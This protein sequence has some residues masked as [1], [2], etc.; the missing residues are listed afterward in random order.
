[1]TQ[2]SPFAAAPPNPYG[3]DFWIGFVPVNLRSNAGNMQLD[4]DPSMRTTTGRALLIQSLLC[5]QTTARGSVIDCP[6]DC[7][8][9]RNY[10][11]DGMTTAQILQLAGTIQSELLKDQRVTSALV[12]GTYSFQTATLS[13]SEAIQSGYGPFTMVLGVSAVTVQLLN[14]NLL[15]GT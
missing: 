8:D 2:P 10:V 6:N 14:A 12:T 5:R 3:I 1:M 7:L 11:S 4:A 9:I 15:S 13:L